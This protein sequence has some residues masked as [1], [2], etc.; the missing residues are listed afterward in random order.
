MYWTAGPPEEYT[1]SNDAG[2]TVG[3]GSLNL[4]NV[5]PGSWNLLAMS[6]PGLEQLRHW[7]GD[8]MLI[9]IWSQ[10]APSAVGTSLQLTPDKG[11]VGV[12]AATLSPTEFLEAIKPVVCY[13]I[14]PRLHGAEWILN[15]AKFAAEY[16]AARMAP[17]IPIFGGGKAGMVQ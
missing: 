2:V 9:P 1:A 6:W 12:L 11:L 10:Y 3:I 8:P 17:V 14:L 4:W 15:A 5:L 13:L 16:K 7:K